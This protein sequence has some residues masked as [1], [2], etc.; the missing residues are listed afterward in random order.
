MKDSLHGKAKF[1]V[2]DVVQTLNGFPAV[3]CA[4]FSTGHSFVYRVKYETTVLKDFDY[5]HI[6]EGFD[7][8]KLQFPPKMVS[9]IVDGVCYS[10]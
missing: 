10:S 2:G 7:E 3:V 9:V 6:E 8:G 4:V 5:V 1:C